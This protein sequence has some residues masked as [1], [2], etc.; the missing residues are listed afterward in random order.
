MGLIL[1]SSQ[2][3][4]AFHPFESKGTG[5]IRQNHGVDLDQGVFNGSGQNDLTLDAVTNFKRFLVTEGIVAMLRMPSMP[6]FSDCKNAPLAHTRYRTSANVGRWF[7]VRTDENRLA[8]IKI[9]DDI[10]GAKLP[11]RYM[12]WCKPSDNCVGP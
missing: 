2:V 11:V 9:V 10:P 6:T 8:A 5:N 3:V 1:A 12:T 7:C 4:L